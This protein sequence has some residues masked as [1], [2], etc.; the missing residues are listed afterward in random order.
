VSE[1]RVAVVGATGAVGNQLLR[2][3]EERNFAISDLRLL[4]SKRSAGIEIEAFGDVISVSELQED[5]FEGID[6]VFS[7]AGTDVARWF[8]PYAVKSGATV[9][10]KSSAWR[11]EDDV[12]LVV[13]EINGQDIESHKG[14]ISCPNCSTIQLVMALSPIHLRHPI[15][16]VI[17]STY[18]AVSGAGALAMKELRQQT[19]DIARDEATEIN[20]LPQQI[21]HNVIPEVETFREED[22]YTSEEWKMAVETRKIMHE[23]NLPISATCVRV[24]VYRGHS[25]AVNLEFDHPV[26]PNSIRQVLQESPGIVVLDDPA[27]HTYPTPLMVEGKDE[28]LVGRIRRDSSNP[29]GIVMWVVGDNLRKGA[30]TNAVQIAENIVR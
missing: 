27:T 4:A 1:P 23:P 26:D 18:Q 2:I 15:R 28:V 16:R 7:A 10:D 3:L 21:L 20:E 9:I 29:N 5:S 6:I 25:E 8:A 13:P 14:I 24:P 19:I 11:Y 17:A 12:P 30:A 22:G